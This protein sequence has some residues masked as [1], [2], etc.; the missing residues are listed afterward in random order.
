MTSPKSLSEEIS[1]IFF[2]FKLS[3][4]IFHGNAVQSIIRVIHHI[5]LPLTSGLFLGR[6]VIYIAVG[7]DVL[8]VYVIKLEP[9]VI[10]FIE[11]V[12]LSRAAVRSGRVRRLNYGLWFYALAAHLVTA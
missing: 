1:Q 10:G 3:L 4:F 9:A 11:I 12:K 2:S 6:V 7:D 8:S 5:V